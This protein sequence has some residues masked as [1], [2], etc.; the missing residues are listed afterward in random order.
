[1]RSWL[2]RLRA[3]LLRRSAEVELAEE[4]RFHLDRQT[5]ALE[6]EGLG[7]EEARR[8][9][10]RRFGN[11]ALTAERCRDQRRLGW[12]EDAADD[13]RRAA[14]S[15]RQAPGFALASVV[16]L[17]LGIGAATALFGPLYSLV[18]SPLP[19]PQ[20][21]RLVRVGGVPMPY[22]W[23][24][25]RLRQ[26]LKPVFSRI[27][28]F[29]GWGSENAPHAFGPALRITGV[30]PGFFRTVGVAPRLGRDFRRGDSLTDGVVISDAVWRTRLHAKLDLSGA[31][32]RVGFATL[33]VAG[34]MPPGFNFPAG[35]QVWVLQPKSVGL[36]FGSP[37]IA[38][39]QPGLSQAAALVRLRTIAKA[40]QVR[41][42]PVTLQPLHDYLLGDR[43]P[44]LWMLWAV[45]VL[46]LLLASA[47]VAN[48]FLV[49]GVRRQP[50]VALRPGA[51][52]RPCAPPAPATRRRLLL[53]LAGAALG[54][55]LA[56]SAGAALRAALPA[57]LG[58]TAFAPQPALAPSIGLVIALALTAA[59]ACGSWPAWR[60][61]RT[62]AGAY[63]KPSGSGLGPAPSGLRRLRSRELL[64]AGQLALALALLIAS[65][66]LARSAE[67]RLDVKFGFPAR[68]VVS[69]TAELPWLPAMAS[70]QLAYF[71]L[72]RADPSL[73]ASYRATKKAIKESGMLFASLASDERDLAY[74][75]E[76]RAKLASIPGVISA[77]VLSPLPFNGQV[78]PSALEFVQLGP[79]RPRVPAYLRYAGSNFVPTLGTRLLAGH[80]FT[81][82]ETETSARVQERATLTYGSPRRGYLLPVVINEALAHR[83]W[84]G[85]SPLGKRLYCAYQPCRVIGVVSNIRESSAD[86]A[87]WPT[88]Y[89]PA[90]F[91]ISDELTFIARLR[92]GTP[93][94]AFLVAA[95]RIVTGLAPGMAPPRIVSLAAL[96][97][98]S[99]TNLRVALWLLAFF[100]A[101]GVIV[102]AVGVY[103]AA[104]QLAATRRRETGV[105]MALGA[106]PG[107]IRRLALWR[108]LR[109]AL[110]ALPIGAFAAWALAR[111]LSHWLFRVGALDARSYAAAA[112][113]LLLL[114]LFAGLWP[115]HCA[116]RAD[117][118]AALRDDG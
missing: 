84:P 82:T 69:V 17:A 27:A 56:V 54:I 29:D 10:L 71:R 100:A 12:A 112:A 42:G 39:L 35:T 18:L 109:L 6:S 68:H 43:R 2:R 3:R 44:L 41:D 4:L 90:Q 103:A 19:F 8:T 61:A 115:A 16:L 23:A 74:Q 93:I 20:A 51:G 53:A 72:V 32:L 22:R 88:V 45:A 36:P 104:A 40:Q 14:R 114:T 83:F 96:A 105:R 70:A 98:K 73:T 102:A 28:Q 97:E 7:A 107:Q 67:A 57:A 11:P 15:L 9:A 80:T 21:N 46:F 108:S 87:V 62:D 65:A 117:P 30:T 64:V 113:M 76:A 31:L 110:A 66:L 106:R 99:W 13:L 81:P 91:N 47:G 49:R 79:S 55:G 63:L 25:P 92:P 85:R 77:A 116:A 38:R 59:L 1:M 37:V 60:A 94:A 86:L 26:A 111:G 5:E 24:S 78:R 89:R 48:L 101:L 33:P 50:E 34:V 58:R 118:A 52:R 75:S 95:R